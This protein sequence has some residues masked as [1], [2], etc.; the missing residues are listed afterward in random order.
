MLSQA[1]PE[2]IQ[3]RQDVPFVHDR[4]L[5]EL[6]QVKHGVLILQCNLEA[7]NKLRLHEHGD[8][9]QPSASNVCAQSV[10]GFCVEVRQ[11]KLPSPNL[12]GGPSSL[13]WSVY[14]WEI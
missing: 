3:G 4:I 5:L 1:V 11:V 14:R 12:N 6:R 8:V 9:Q 10:Q 13:K 2:I 7:S